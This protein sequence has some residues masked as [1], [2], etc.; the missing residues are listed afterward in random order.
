[1]E[2]EKCTLWI[3]TE[4]F[5]PDETSTAYIMGEIANAFVD[6]YQ[7][8]VICGPEIYDKRKRLDQNNK[9]KLDA[10]MEIMRANG[11]GLDKST[12]KG[13]MLSFLL[14]SHRLLKLAKM[15]IK[16]DDKVLM[17]TNPAPLVVLMSRLKKVI[18]FELNILVHDIFP[19][20]TIP[21]GI[22]LPA[23]G[24]LKRLFDKAY[25]RADKLV[26]LGRD[27][28]KVMRGKVTR[29]HSEQEI[30]VIEN[31]ADIENIIP[32]TFPKG[33]IILQYAG[34][35]GRVQGL[36]KV[37]E[38]L[39][40]N[41][42]LHLYGTG[43]MEESLKGM[44]HP[45]VF[46]HGPYFRSQQNEVLSACDI[47][48]VTLQEGMY[49]LGVPSKTYNILASGRP[50]MF[51]GPEGSEIDLLVREKG[52]GYCGWPKTWNKQ[53]LANMGVKARK[54]AVSEYSKRVILNKFLNL[55]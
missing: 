14:M 3:V 54:L 35:I 43:A 37:I 13:K 29:F 40:N 44:K 25:S 9:F 47:A 1:M 48:I 36:G 15:Y 46:F 33:R 38:Q 30:T 27:M 18:G 23:Y 6:K 21:A 31:W 10:S 49:G 22:K 52:V 7:V 11:A 26:V 51:F 5:P 2:N 8:K 42:E 19:E 28:E 53:E 45:G 16:K 20:N 34:N 32:K 50:I 12:F 24:L 41:M 17:V 4:L 55:I 39:P